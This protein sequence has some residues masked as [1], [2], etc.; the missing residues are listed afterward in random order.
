MYIVVGGGHS[1]PGSDFSA[2][3]AQVV[4]PTT[5]DID[6]TAL[7]WDFFSRFSVPG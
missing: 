5:F 4:G 1:W 6:A 3:I 7:A 2:S